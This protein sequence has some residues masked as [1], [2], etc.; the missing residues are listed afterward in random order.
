MRDFVRSH[1]DYRH[2]SLVYD[3]I[4]YDLLLE[5]ERISL[6]TSRPHDFLPPRYALNTDPPGK[7]SLIEEASR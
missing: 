5:C 2:D 3:R 4:N 6:G 1:P 7:S